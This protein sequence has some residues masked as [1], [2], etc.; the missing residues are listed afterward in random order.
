MNRG[1]VQQILVDLR[2]TAD[3]QERQEEEVLKDLGMLRVLASLGLLIGQF[4]HEVRHDLVALAADVN[5][6]KR[7]NLPDSVRDVAA[8]IGDNVSSLRVFASYFDR[9]IADNARR[10][11]RPQDL[12]DVL[13]RFRQ[14]I[15]SRTLTQNLTLSID[16]KGA[17]LLTRPMHPSEW[18]SILFNLFTNAE[19]AI[20]KARVPGKVL[21]R[22]GREG[23]RVF[24]ELLDNGCGIPEADR[25]RIF[26]AFFTT[27]AT[28]DPEA[29]EAEHAQG[30][31]L[32]L[33]IV[34][35]IVTSVEGTVRVVDAPEGY[36][37]CIRVEVPAIK[38]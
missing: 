11:L 22:A 7:G 35:D 20:R 16:I 3:S 25:D 12:R 28:P 33:K 10:D 37:T 38:T 26:D 19:K 8:R 4:T 5:A 13:N 31:G 29:P 14:I 18:A 34:R 27:T 32:G 6:L 2:A 30:S 1:T 23:E 17:A 36:R 15:E 9:T 24:V 21:L